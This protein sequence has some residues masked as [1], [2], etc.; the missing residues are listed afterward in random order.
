MAKMLKFNLEL[1]I[2]WKENSKS[3]RAGEKAMIRWP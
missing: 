1:T 3:P 2:T